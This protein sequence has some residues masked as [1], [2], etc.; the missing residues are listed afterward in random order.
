MAVGLTGGHIYPAIALAE[1]LGNKDFKYLFVAR[2]KSALAQS[3][4]AGRGLS[5]LELETRGM[6]RG[7]FDALKNGFSFLAGQWKAWRMLSRAFKDW[8]P[9][10]VIGFGSY[11]A[12]PAVLAAR[13]QG[14]QTMIFEPNA[15]M[16]VA[17]L[18]LSRISDKTVSVLMD[19]YVQ[20]GPVLRKSILEAGLMEPAQA[21]KALGLKEGL[22]CL[23]VFGGS[24]GASA[25]NHA[26]CA[27][28]KNLAKK[29]RPFQAIHV[30]GQAEF[31]KISDFYRREGLSHIHARPYLEEIGLAYR[32]SH[33]A[34]SRSGAITVLELAHFRLPSILVPLGS[35]TEGHQL[36]NARYLERLGIATI[37]PENPAL[38]SKL[39]EALEKALGADSPRKAPVS[40]GRN[41][42]SKIV[43]E[44]LKDK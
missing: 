27:A 22:P 38:A 16:G 7:A 1:Q 6:P 18:L 21:R 29:G 10:L 8:S 30:T 12:F 40:E 28:L 17:N 41:H 5:L 4:I 34:V 39:E 23:L 13:L 19:G 24:Q 33:A 9:D 35:S 31:E 20:V 26:A 36:E 14:I 25:I 37:I 15:K 43:L 42:F 11:V 2:S 44:V 32:A 3:L